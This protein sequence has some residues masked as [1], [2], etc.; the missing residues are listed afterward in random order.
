MVFDQ[1]AT[2]DRVSAIAASTPASAAYCLFLT[3]SRV[4]RL[5]SPDVIIDK[6]APE[7]APM[8]TMNTIAKTSAAPRSPV[9]SPASSGAR[10][11]PNRGAAVT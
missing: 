5:C 11:R 3:A 8:T 9:P 4:V 2:A 6:V 10:S 1:V 7:I